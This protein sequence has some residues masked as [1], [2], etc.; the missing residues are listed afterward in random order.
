[1][2]DEDRAKKG[3][4]MQC[5]NCGTRNQV[6]VICGFNGYFD[7]DICGWMNVLGNR[8]ESIEGAPVELFVEKALSQK[9]WEDWSKL[10]WGRWTVRETIKKLSRN[11][12]EVVCRVGH[13]D[14][15]CSK[16]DVVLFVKPEELARAKSI[17]FAEEDL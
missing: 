5:L 1:M 7:C 14:K 11:G 8:N 12:V 9:T 16:D 4:Q 17:L 2:T 15:G 10:A 13:P 3:N 6:G